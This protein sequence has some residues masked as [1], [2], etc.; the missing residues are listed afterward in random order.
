MDT[1]SIMAASGVHCAVCSSKFASFSKLK[2]HLQTRCHRLKEL[3]LQ[4]LDM[5]PSE[6]I[7]ASLA[8]Y[9]S[10]EPVHLLL[11][12]IST[13]VM[14]LMRGNKPLRQLIQLVRRNS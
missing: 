14:K 1:S 2:Q 7:V 5:E 8:S 3:N 12:Q 6:V 10:I 9:N 4:M 13:H 11:Y